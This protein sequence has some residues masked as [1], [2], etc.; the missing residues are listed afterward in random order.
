MRTHLALAF[1]LASCDVLPQQQ[2]L[3]NQSALCDRA[4]GSATFDLVRPRDSTIAPPP[5]PC[6]TSSGI[7]LGGGVYA[8]QGTF[9]STGPTASQLCAAGYQPCTMAGSANLSQC[10]SLPGYFIANVYGITDNQGNGTVNCGISNVGNGFNRIWA[11]CG[12]G[13][14]MTSSN[15][16]Q[17]GGFPTYVDCSGA[18]SFNCNK[19]STTFD[20]ISNSSAVNGVLCCGP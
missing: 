13:T 7:S 5:K 19:S 3:C 15:N 8:C 20:M 1:L 18:G 9:S 17:C 2:V 12:K 6:A 14:G 10:P 4:D 11:G 16:M